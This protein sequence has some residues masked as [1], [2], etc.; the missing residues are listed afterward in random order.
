MVAVGPVICCSPPAL[1]VVM[2]KRKRVFTPFCGVRNMYRV[3]LL[4]KSKMRAQLAV[5]FSR[6]QA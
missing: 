2:A 1:F 3:V 5:E 4:P 6:T